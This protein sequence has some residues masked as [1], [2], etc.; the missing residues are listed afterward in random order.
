MCPDQPTNSCPLPAIP[1][2]VDYARHCGATLKIDAE[3]GRFV[4]FCRP[5]DLRPEA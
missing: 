5:I 4:F 2:Y 3:G 1:G